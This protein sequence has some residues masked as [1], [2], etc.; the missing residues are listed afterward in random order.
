MQNA[1]GIDNR[2]LQKVSAKMETIAITFPAKRYHATPWDAHVNEGRIEWPPSPW[3]LLRA[4]LAVG[5]NKLGWIGEPS[6]VA[7]SAL[8]KLSQVNPSYGLP[9]ATETHTR[10]YMPT[11]D[12]TAKV[13]DAFLRFNEAD[14]RLYVRFDAEL[15]AD[16]R[17]ALSELV[18]GLTYLGRAESWAEARLLSSNDIAE[19]PASSTWCTANERGAGRTVRLLSAMASSEFSSW[20]SECVTV[21]AD[22][23]EQTERHKLEAKGKTLSPAATKKVRD[24][25]TLNYPDD[26]LCALQLETSTWQSQG[27]PQPPGSRWVDYCVPDSSLD[28]QPLKPLA[29]SPRLETFEAVLLAIDGEGKSGTVR[30]LMTRAL[31][32][33]ELLHSESIRKATKEFHFGNLLELTGKANDGNVLHGHQHAHWFP[34]SLYGQRRID[35][36]L[37]WRKDGFSGQSIATLSSIR[38]AYAKGIDRLSINLAGMGSVSEMANQLGIVPQCDPSGLAPLSRGCIWQ[39]TT[40]LVFRKFVHKRGKKTPEGQIREELVQRG[41]PAPIRIE[42]W[43]SSKMVEDHLKGYVLNRRQGKQQ[44]P[45]A[46]SWAA[47]IEFASPQQGPICLGYASHFGLGLFSA[48]ELQQR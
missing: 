20:R 34:L 24:K 14:A 33:M 8:I 3:R 23:L 12:K 7:K 6:D 17:K 19:I 30:P 29:T 16:E 13:F 37:V 25:A 1:N 4:L 38:W 21:A 47:T 22:A 40:P 28:Q 10:H 18:D 39:S 46:A 45:C 35:H 48:I 11:K 9:K 15:D 27:W 2:Y 43:S 42:L 32:L 26:L 31:P 36:V 44:P 41:F 5:Y